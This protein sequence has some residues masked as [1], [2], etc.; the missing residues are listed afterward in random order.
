MFKVGDK[1]RRIK[2]VFYNM[3]P[4]DEGT[5]VKVLAGHIWLK[6]FNSEKEIIEERLGYGITYFEL[7][8]S[9]KSTSYE[10]YN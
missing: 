8:K 2:E 3:K 9:S 6:E 5:I 10:V 4:G 7:V 1:V